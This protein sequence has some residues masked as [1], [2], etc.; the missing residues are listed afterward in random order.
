MNTAR[1]C[2]SGRRKATHLDSY[3]CAMPPVHPI[4]APYGCWASPVSLDLAVAGRRRLSE[5]KADADDLYWLESQ[6]D[7]DGRTA[8]M[9]R[10]HG[11]VR[12][13][14]R[15]SDDVATTVNTY[16]GGAF[17]VRQG[18]A[19]WCLA[20]GS[21][22]EMLTAEQVRI[23][24]T[25]G[26]P[27]LRYADVRVYPHQGLMLAVRE[28]SSGPGEPIAQIVCLRQ[29]E[30]GV[31][32][33]NRDVTLVA[34]A[35]FYANPELAPD[36]RLAWIEWNHPDMVWDASTLKVGR[37]SADGDQ[38]MDIVTVMDGHSDRGQ[39]VSV[40]HPYW[41]ADGRLAFMC[42]ISGF[43]NLMV[44][45]GAGLQAVHQDACDFDGPA[46]T[47]GNTA[48]AQLDDARVLGWFREDAMTYLASIDLRDGKVTRHGSFADVLC[49]AAEG[50]HG[51]AVVER[52]AAP[53]ALVELDARGGPSVLQAA[54]PEPDADYVSLA[55]SITVGGQA[56][57]VQAWY[58]PPANADYVG[59]RQQHPPLIVHPHSGPTSFASNAYDPTVQFWTSRGFAYLVVNY[60]GSAGFG[61]AYRDRLRSRWGLLDVADC[62]E[63][64]R[65]MVDAGLADPGKLAV[66]GGSAGGYT[67]LRLLTTSHMFAA[68]VSMY[69]VADLVGLQLSTHKLEAHYNE[70]LIGP[71][72]QDRARYEERSPINHVDQLR[73]PMLILQGRD[74]PVVPVDQAIRMASAI[75]G[76][77][78]PVALIV[79]DGEGHGWRRTA[80]RRTALEAERSFYMQV[81][82]LV[83]AEPVSALAIDNLP[84]ADSG[85]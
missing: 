15:T 35:D 45:D 44:W 24:V 53:A 9:R 77:G 56:G 31:S 51:Y 70:G 76:R 37:L 80:T 62:E 66:S 27:F 14:S 4:T 2:L 65:V 83:P 73:T 22:I 7:Q 13:I 58:Y 42:D 33:D 61:R 8:L 40:Q 85:G 54:G 63:A 46:W 30:I 41:L 71:W 25:Q 39:S 57:P 28:D 82:G 49:V 18:V 67:V 5:L 17:D 10:R 29:P 74:D 32:A 81:F 64:A 59:P 1:L 6:P 3:A 20:G 36:G 47:L 19:V 48:Y 16:G 79:F 34:G 23:S 50:G 69:G 75:R 26:V 72:P 43:W 12:E 84:L 78:V 55:R 60:S 52:P 11:Q 21:A 38:L 68:G